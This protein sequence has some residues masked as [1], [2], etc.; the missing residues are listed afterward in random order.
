MVASAWMRVYFV[1]PRVFGTIVNN[2]RTLQAGCVFTLGMF[3]AGCSGGSGAGSSSGPV[4][5]RLQGSKGDKYSYTLGV[6]MTADVSSVPAPPANSPMAARL[7]QMRK[8]EQSL[9]MTRTVDAELKN[10]SG[11]KFTWQETT[12]DVRASGKGA[13]AAAAPIVEQE[14]GQVKTKDF[15][16]NGKPV[17]PN[18][19]DGSSTPLIIV[20]SDKPVNAGDTWTDNTTVNGK[21]IK[22]TYKLEKFEKV[23]NF[24]TAAIAV[25]VNAGDD[26]KTSQP[27]MIWV[28]KATGRPVKAEGTI[29]ATQSGMKMNIAIKMNRA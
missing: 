14:K 26:L 22:T 7:E 18:T 5:L 13:F 23:G 17:D 21:T 11:G 20:F 6:K 8:D 4:T 19:S 28:D 1:L 27:I 3:V 12:K 29:L 2:M 24:D 16:A 10:A 15:Y 25:T 9:E